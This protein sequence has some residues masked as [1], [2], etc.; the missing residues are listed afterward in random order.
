MKKELPLPALIAIVA[1]AVLIIGGIG[2]S[3]FRNA[4]QLG[5]EDPELAQKQAEVERARR[6]DGG[7]A[8]QP[9]NPPQGYSPGRE[10]EAQARQSTP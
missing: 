1:V 7:Q 5:G 4:A 8:Q 6:P 10:A 3:Y 2:F 9:V